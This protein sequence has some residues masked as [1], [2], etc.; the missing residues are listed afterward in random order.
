MT[1]NEIKEVLGIDI[2]TN[3]K[4]NL[5][6]YLKS[7]YVFQELEKGRRKSHIAKDM[8]SSDCGLNIYL[9][10]K[11]KHRKDPLFIRVQNA[12][13][14]YDKSEI[15]LFIKKMK[16]KR[17]YS[18]YTSSSG[19]DK[20]NELRTIVEEIKHPKQ[21]M[22]IVSVALRGIKTKLNEKPLNEWTNSDWG[23][24]YKITNKKLV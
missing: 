9:K 10:N 7:M 16:L 17:L 21:P 19:I 13:N 22:Q 2:T 3:K 5:I 18:S 1:I 15:N 14:N 8:N 24:Y 12:F 4:S 6:T 20:L 23:Q 11:E